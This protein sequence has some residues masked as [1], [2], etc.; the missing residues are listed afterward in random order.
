MSVSDLH[1]QTC[2]RLYEISRRHNRVR[3]LVATELRLSN[4]PVTVE[5]MAE[6]G[7]RRWDLRVDSFLPSGGPA[8]FDVGITHPCQ[9]SQLNGRDLRPLQAADAMFAAKCKRFSEISH[10]HPPNSSFT[11]L[12]F[13]AFGAFHPAVPAFVYNFSRRHGVNL[14]QGLTWSSNSTVRFL[15]QALSV[16]VHSGSSLTVIRSITSLSS[17][18]LGTPGL[19][20]FISSASLVK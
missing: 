2:P 17:S 13:E 3:D 20:G 19:S 6:V 1:L 8:F 11:P 15:S 16:A 4:I 7:K 5:P 14:R 18:L 12:I 10:L 9:L